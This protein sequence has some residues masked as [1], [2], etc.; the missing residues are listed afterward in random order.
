MDPASEPIWNQKPS[1]GK[2]LLNAGT[3]W[4][5]HPRLPL[6]LAFLAILLTLPALWLGWQLDDY[7]HRVR[8]L[9]P[10]PLIYGQEKIFSAFNFMNGGPEMNRLGMDLGI[11]PWWTTPD[12]RFA[13]LRYLSSLSM[14][15]DY[16]LW[17][18]WPSLMHLHSLLWYAVLVA[19]AAFFYRR[20]MGLTWAA[21]LAALLYAVD[22]SHALPAA[23][24][25]NRN[26]LLAVFFGVLSLIAYDGWRRAGRKWS[27]LVCPACLGLALLS[28]E[29]ALGAA[30]YLFAYALFLDQSRWSR[31]LLSLLP[32][33][34][35]LLTWAMIYH[36]FGFGT[37]G[38]GS[39]IDPLENPGEFANTFI[40]RA[41]LLLLG[42]W[43][44]FPADMGTFFSKQTALV[45]SL[46]FI[47]ILAFILVP[48]T[49]RNRI[50]R[51]WAL[52]MILSIVPI[53][54]TIPS[55]RLLLFV[56]LGAM[57]LL[58]QFLTGLV[59]A[60]VRLPIIRLWRIPAKAIGIILIAFH[61]IISPLAMPPFAYSIKLLGDFFIAPIKYVPHDSKIAHQDLILVNP[62]DYMFSVNLIR[63]LK[64][65]EGKPGPLRIRALSVGPVSVEI[66]RL[67]ECSLKVRIQGGLFNGLTGHLFRSP[68]YPMKVGQEIHIVG[69][70]ARV[71]RLDK[72]NG[73]EEIVYRFSVPLEDASLRWLQWEN[74][75][76]VPFVPPPIGKSIILPAGKPFDFIQRWIN[77]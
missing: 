42:Q 57:G 76:Y 41:P 1:W 44:P 5:T 11:L 12:F 36:Y 20:I 22:E 73:P 49:R 13:F 25:A 10:S 2:H 32:C 71:N 30:G 34:I 66:H 47:A 31:R 17:P 15:L 51:F 24:L 43:S 58:A 68:K 7:L 50:A 74:E 14:W 21:G 77:L 62:P 46:A 75:T 16:Q 63:A 72:D 18:N 65:M 26:A 56:G 38:S 69:M 64:Y 33:G 37:H 55:N 3:T 53:T 29:T 52:G 23:W 19:A 40:L 54:A 60:S 35:V 59:E 9:S 70:S 45:L 67:D 39:Y 48:L 4:L 28:G 27:A 8:M 6:Y 61:L